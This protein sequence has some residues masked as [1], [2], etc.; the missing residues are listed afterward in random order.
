MPSNNSLQS[1]VNYDQ[2]IIRT[3]EHQ[4]IDYKKRILELEKIVSLT[5]EEM[6]E[7]KIW[8]AEKRKQNSK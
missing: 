8:L 7:F 1:R 6:Q 3:L 4:V 5:D 2:I